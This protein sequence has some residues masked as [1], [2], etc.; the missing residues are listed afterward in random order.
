M[1]YIK[2]NWSNESLLDVG[3]E[4]PSISALGPT[5]NDPSPFSLRL[6]VYN[7]TVDAG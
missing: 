2:C 6:D 3:I 7:L 1:C 5:I 4:M